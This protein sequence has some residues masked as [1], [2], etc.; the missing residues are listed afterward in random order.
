MTLIRKNGNKIEIFRDEE[1]I[2]REIFAEL[3]EYYGDHTDDLELAMSQQRVTE[4]NSVTGP[5]GMIQV[6]F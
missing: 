6:R 2:N 5:C 3:S 1:D 4:D